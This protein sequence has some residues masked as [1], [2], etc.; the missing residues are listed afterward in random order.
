MTFYSLAALVAQHSIASCWR[1]T[2]PDGIII[3][4]PALLIGVVV[5]IDIRQKR[6]RREFEIRWGLKYLQS[7]GMK[8]NPCIE[9]ISSWVYS[10]KK[11]TIAPD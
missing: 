6:T 8:E 10:Q 5:L 3:K 2:F 4:Y 9:A 7:K 1:A 11:A